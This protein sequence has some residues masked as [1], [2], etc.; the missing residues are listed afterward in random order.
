MLCQLLAEALVAFGAGCIYRWAVSSSWWHR[1][2][3]VES[4]GGE[5]EGLGLRPRQ[6]VLC[7][8]LAEA[9]V[10]FGAGCIYRWAVSS[11]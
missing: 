8:L 3:A 5:C 2:V 6:E 11:S 9:L 10:A 4:L 1:A 7:Q